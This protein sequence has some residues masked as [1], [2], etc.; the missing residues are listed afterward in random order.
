MTRALKSLLSSTPTMPPFNS[1][2]DCKLPIVT[3]NTSKRTRLWLHECS[4][5]TSILH[6]SNYTALAPASYNVH[7]PR[8]L[9]LI[10]SFNARP[11]HA[12]ARITSRSARANQ[13]ELAFLTVLSPEPRNT[14]YVLI[15]QFQIPCARRCWR[16]PETKPRVWHRRLHFSPTYTATRSPR[17]NLFTMSIYDHGFL[18]SS[19]LTQIE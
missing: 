15:F 5:H 13:R 1:F 2:N 19:Y 12:P 11:Q 17:P 8:H 16:L 7:L 10:Y 4:Y 9:Q 18:S 14:I 3:S 6:V